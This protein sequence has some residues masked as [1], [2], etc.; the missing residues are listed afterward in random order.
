MRVPVPGISACMNMGVGIKE[1]DINN[2]R[3]IQHQERHSITGETSTYGETLTYGDIN[4][5]EHAGTCR[6]SGKSVAT[7]CA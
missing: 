7:P 3:D 2:R 6:K 5:Q 4:M 1:A